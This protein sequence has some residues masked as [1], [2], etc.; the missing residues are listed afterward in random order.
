MSQPSPSSLRS[1]LPWVLLHAGLLGLGGVALALPAPAQGWGVLVVV[2]AYAAAL[3]ATCRWAGRPDLVPLAVLC[4]LVSLFQVLPDWALVEVA[5]TL[6]FPDTGG[7]RVGDAVPVAMALMW[8]AP[9]FVAVALAGGRPGRAAAVAAMVFLGAE[10][11]APWVGLWEPV[12]DTVRVAG[13]AVYVLPAEA[14][15]GWA[16][17]LAAGLV[18]EASWPRRVGAALAV[19]TFYTGALVLCHLALD[20]ADRTLTV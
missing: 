8:T 12:G 20:V 9:L 16:V 1:A 17:A 14:A 11:A 13:V 2:V 4:A 6:R 15:L 7:P 5:G 10:V 3:P 19:S 18:R